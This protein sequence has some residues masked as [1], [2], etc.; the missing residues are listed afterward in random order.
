MGRESC[1]KKDKIAGIGT[2]QVNLKS[3][4]FNEIIKAEVL[5]QKHETHLRIQYFKQ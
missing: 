2:D 5:K 3:Q 1:V 4:T